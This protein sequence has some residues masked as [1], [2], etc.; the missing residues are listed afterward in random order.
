M[1]LTE[2]HPYLKARRQMVVEENARQVEALEH[3]ARATLAAKKLQRRAN[4]WMG[5][6]L[7]ALAVLAVDI[8][9]LLLNAR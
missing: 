6:A 9:L 4:F 3:F 5:V 8:G 7:I 1:S 2:L